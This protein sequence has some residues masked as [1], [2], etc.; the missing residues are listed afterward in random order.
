M[1]EGRIGNGAPLFHTQMDQLP[2][3]T[4]PDHDWRI[5]YLLSQC[6]G[7][8]VAIVGNAE[9]IVG[10]GQGELI[11]SHDCVIRFSRVYA[12]RYPV[13]DAGART[14]VWIMNKGAMAECYPQMPIGEQAKC[15]MLCRDNVRAD[16]WYRPTTMGRKLFRAVPLICP[17]TLWN[18]LRLNPT[19]IYLCGQD[20]F[21]SADP[22]AGG[23]GTPTEV[24]QHKHGTSCHDHRQD[25][26][27]TKILIQTARVK[28]T[29][30]PI[31]QEVMDNT[32]G[33][34]DE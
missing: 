32:R 3:L 30:D 7:R 28:I 20:F 1:F 25:Q 21:Q 14:D 17:V 2:T 18:V 11:D 34:W 6:H 29:C 26:R 8:S 24:R 10:T 4:G 16:G 5:G 15:V 9:S 12:H 33:L 22:S 31:L 19:S 27:A 23:R 13:K